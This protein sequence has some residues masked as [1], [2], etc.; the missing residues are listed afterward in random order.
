MP[1]IEDWE[2]EGKDFQ[3]YEAQI[4]VFHLVNAAQ[5]LVRQSNRQSRGFGV[6]KENLSNVA[7]RDISI[8]LIG[9]ATRLVVECSEPLGKIVKC[10][11]WNP[12]WDA[13]SETNT[14]NFAGDTL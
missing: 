10:K 14:D 9:D 1:F 8:G 3:N 11:E 6:S 12:S 2:A 7:L 13:Y 4:M 5:T